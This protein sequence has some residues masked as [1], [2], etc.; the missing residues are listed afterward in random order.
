MS[1]AAARAVES[2]GAR[3]IPNYIISMCTSVSDL[4]EVYVLLKEVGLFHPGE[5]PRTEVFAEPL[6]E[7]IGDLR[8]AALLSRRPGGGR[9]PAAMAAELQSSPSPH[10]AR[11]RAPREAE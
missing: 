11:L 1:A 2:L 10:G 7:T 6:F 9:G 4:L 5:T 3:A 8:A